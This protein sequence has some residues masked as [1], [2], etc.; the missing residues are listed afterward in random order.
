[1]KRIFNQK[2]SGMSLIE[3]M[4]VVALSSIIFIFLYQ[5]YNSIYRAVQFSN[6]TASL[7]SKKALIFFH[8]YNDCSKLIYP[9]NLSKICEIAYQTYK[10]PERESGDI[11]KKERENETLKKE[12]EKLISP[13]PQ[14]TRTETDITLSFLSTNS[15][16]SSLTGHHL[17]KISYQL[18]KRSSPDQKKEKKSEKEIFYYTLLRKEVDCNDFLDTSS[19]NKKE[20]QDKFY[21][22]AEKIAEPSIT[23]WFPT[24]PIKKDKNEQENEKKNIFPFKE[25]YAEPKFTEEK[26]IKKLTME[27]FFKIS[28]IPY[29][30]IFE[31]ILISDDESKK[32][33]FSFIVPIASAELF[34][35]IICDYPTQQ[36]KREESTHHYENKKDL[37]EGAI[38]SNDSKIGENKLNESTN[39]IDQ[40]QQEGGIAYVV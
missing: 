16:L 10:K 1:M 36:K 27:N 25:W 22:L 12:F 15:L 30:I 2:I 35:E 24:I 23:F 13:F 3:L 7:E 39:P 8:F 14:T 38:E 19:K 29:Y 32:T 17:S 4:L 34:H 31:G 28:A 37:E 20:N 11:N 21:L 40:S 9:A 33:P 18:K 5:A 6:A 26:D